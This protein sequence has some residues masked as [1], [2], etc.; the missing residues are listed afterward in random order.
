[1][2]LKTKTAI[3]NEITSLFADNTTGNIDPSDLRTVVQDIV[4]SYADWTAAGVLNFC[5]TGVNFNSANTDNSITITLPT[6]RTRYII[7]GVSISNASHTLVTATCGL[8][9]AAAGGGVA[10]VSAG[11]AI[12]VSA[13]TD[14]TVNNFQYVGVNSANT[15]SYT[16]G[17]LFFRV[18]T[19]EGAAATGDVTVAIVPLP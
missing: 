2:T 18:G 7:Y 10:I 14:A 12:T 1:M 15:R 8:F 16:A 5:V 13:T 3:G 19:A 4:D 11:T 9:T 6:G 17:T